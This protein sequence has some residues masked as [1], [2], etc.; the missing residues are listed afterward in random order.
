MA[1]PILSLP[2]DTAD[3][4][5]AGNGSVTT[6]T[7]NGTLDWVCTTS[8]TVPTDTQIKAGQDHTGAAAADSG[9]QAVT[10]S[11]EQILSPAPSGLTPST[12]YYI[13]FV[14]THSHPGSELFTFTGAPLQATMRTREFQPA[15]GRRTFVNRAWPL[16]DLE[17]GLASIGVAQRGND[18]DEGT[19]AG[20]PQGVDG[21]CPLRVNGRYI[22]MNL[23]VPKG[24]NWRE[25]QG[26]QVAHKP[27]GGR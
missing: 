1:A 22:A 25:L 17:S 19:T 6:D 16:I 18:Y 7:S 27:G 4:S 10:A 14:H 15:P 11:G 3:G 26:V 2:V 24:A 5:T 20:L 9:T 13:H 12:T 8:A 23:T 21:S